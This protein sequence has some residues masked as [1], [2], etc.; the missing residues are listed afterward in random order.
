LFF[1]EEGKNRVKQRP[2][3][4][5]ASGERKDGMAGT[6][7]GEPNLKRAATGARSDHGGWPV[8]ISTITAPTDLEEEEDREATYEARVN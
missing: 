7:S 3:K 5:R 2:R 6:A 8:A 4:W 1:V